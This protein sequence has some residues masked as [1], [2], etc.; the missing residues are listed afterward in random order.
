MIAHSRGYTLSPGLCHPQAVRAVLGALPYA[1]STVYLHT[2]AALMPR[3]R[4]TWASWNCI[5]GSGAGSDQAPVCVTYWLNRLQDLP[6]G[7]RASP[8]WRAHA[9]LSGS[10]NQLI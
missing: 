6:A 8:R 2:D 7:A 1:D 10:C 5:Q 4:A 3:R 9:P